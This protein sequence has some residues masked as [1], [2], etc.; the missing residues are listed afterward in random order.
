MRK[1]YSDLGREIINHNLTKL[2]EKG[3]KSM[4]DCSLDEAFVSA[5]KIAETDEFDEKLDTLNNKINNI[6]ETFTESKEEEEKELIPE[7]LDKVL[8]LEFLSPEDKEEYEKYDNLNNSLTGQLNG[9]YLEIE[10]LNNDRIKALKDFDIPS[11]VEIDARLSQL[12][13]DYK[14]KYSKGME[15]R[16]ELISKKNEWDISLNQLSESLKDETWDM[17]KSFDA[18]K[19]QAS[20]V[21]EYKKNKTYEMVKEF[22]ETFPKEKRKDV[23]Q[24]PRLK[25]LLDSDYNRIVAEYL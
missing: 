14:E 25:E 21:K 4:F 18:S 19:Y 11:V 16:Q 22:I 13:N 7:W 8:D 20:V 23:L 2:H 6:N 9:I 10:R 24:N 3:G 15:A 1:F 17:K 12:T 5:K